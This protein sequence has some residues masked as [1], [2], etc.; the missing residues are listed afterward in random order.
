[1]AGK[2]D[3]PRPFS[4]PRKVFFENHDNTFKKPEQEPDKC[5]VCGE[6]FEEACD[7]PQCPYFEE[8][9]DEPTV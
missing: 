9:E 7:V 1:M 3:P 2:G 6:T 5:L 8:Y 4:V